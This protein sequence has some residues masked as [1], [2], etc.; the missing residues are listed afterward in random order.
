MSAKCEKYT[1]TGF[2]LSI[3]QTSFHRS[4]HKNPKS[5]IYEMKPGHPSH[6]MRSIEDIMITPSSVYFFG[7]MS[8]YMILWTPTHEGKE[9]M[10]I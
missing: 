9:T 4:V 1:Q 6:L 8:S 3:L 7:Q 2:Q 5:K 10:S